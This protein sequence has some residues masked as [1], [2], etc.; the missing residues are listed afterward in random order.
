MYTMFF[1]TCFVKIC[2]NVFNKISIEDNDAYIGHEKQDMNCV[3]WKE[4]WIGVLSYH[5]MVAHIAKKNQGNFIYL[6]NHPLYIQKEPPDRIQRSEES[7]YKKIRVENI[8]DM[9]GYGSEPIRDVYIIR[10]LG[11]KLYIFRIFTMQGCYATF[12]LTSPLH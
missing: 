3:T 10:I 8:S 7:R 9:Y 1:I 12:S 2:I 11:V 5:D 6:A 4:D